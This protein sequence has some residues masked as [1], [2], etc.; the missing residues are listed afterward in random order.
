MKMISEELNSDTLLSLVSL[1]VKN[2][3]IALGERK[4]KVVLQ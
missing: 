2:L 3:K 1:P 4:T